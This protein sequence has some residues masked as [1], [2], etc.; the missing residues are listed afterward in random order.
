MKMVLTGLGKLDIVPAAQKTASLEKGQI[1]LKYEEV[2]VHEV[3]DESI[4]NIQLQVEKKGG[5]ISTF[6]KAESFKISA[7]KIHF[8]NVIFNLLDNANKYTPVT[9]NLTLNIVYL[10]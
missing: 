3:I 4:K 1:I 2:D 5:G 6:F 9:P 10:S 7:D 8:T